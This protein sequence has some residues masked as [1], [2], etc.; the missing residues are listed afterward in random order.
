MLL[1]KEFWV[2]HG[3]VEVAGVP[4]DK[5][6]AK[7]EDNILIIEGHSKYRY[8]R[9]EL[10]LKEHPSPDTLTVRYENGLLILYYET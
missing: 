5:V 10:D 6:T 3:S 1:P 8:I 4:K 7:V 9:Y 2:E